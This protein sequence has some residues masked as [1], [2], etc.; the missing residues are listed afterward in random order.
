MRSQAGHRGR[1]HRPDRRQD[2]RLQGPRGQDRPHGRAYPPLDDGR[3][4]RGRGQGPARDGGPGRQRL[5]AA[6]RYGTEPTKWTPFSWRPASLPAT[7]STSRPGP[8]RYPG[9][10]GGRR[11][12]DRRGLE[13]AFRRSDR[14][15]RRRADD[16]AKSRDRRVGIAKRE[17]LKSKPGDRIQREG[18]QP[19]PLW[20]A[21]FFCD[22]EI[23]CNPC[24]TVCPSGSIELRERKG[25]LLD[26]PY[27]RGSDCK[28]C[29]ACV[30]ACPGLA[31]SL[32]RA[33]DD[34]VV[35]GCLALR[36][37]ARLRGGRSPGAPGPRRPAGRGRCPPQKSVQRKIQNLG[38]PLQSEPGQC[39]KSDRLARPEPRGDRCGARRRRAAFHVAP[40]EAILCRCERVS[41]GEVVDFI[42]EN[43]ARDVNQLKAIRAGMGSCGS[44]PCA[45][46]YAAAFRA[47]GV[48]PATVAEGRLRPLEMEVPLG[49]LAERLSRAAAESGALGSSA[50][51]A[52]DQAGERP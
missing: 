8:V 12:G 39:H 27:F 33:V 22:E 47:A 35:R 21:V 48:D 42:R 1:R 43:Q 17:V 38:P 23:P 37:H 28:G 4:G 51:S 31:I 6:P 16:R 44:K 32:V 52:S 45:P 15:L 46:L 7:S 14:R 20:K 50:P 9:S 25:N 3:L 11:R 19:S 18:V 36:V 40:D 49:V 10:Q 13:R 29:S 2:Q 5:A 26:L 30:A 41:F 24:A 34:Q